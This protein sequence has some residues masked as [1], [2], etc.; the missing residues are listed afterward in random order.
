MRTTTE[1]PR[2]PKRDLAHEF[3][4]ASGAQP[5]DNVIIAGAGNLELLI[6]FIQRGFSHVVCQSDHGAH[7][8]TQPG[9]ILIAPNLKSKS[10]FHSV[11]TLLVRDLSPHGVL[12]ISRDQNP[13]FTEWDLR[14][15]LKEN[16]FRAVR[17]FDCREGAGTILCARKEV[18]SVAHAA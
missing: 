16:G 8:T 9:D 15:C 12:V 1:E 3:I 7:I 18:A 2:S 14:R 5:A 10:D 13:S 4:T 6:E 11:M 17:Q